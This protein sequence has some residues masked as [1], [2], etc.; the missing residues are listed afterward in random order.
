MDTTL[1]DGFYFDPLTSRSFLIKKG[2]VPPWVKSKPSEWAK[3]KTG[4]EEKEMNFNSH[5][6]LP[7]YKDMDI[8]IDRLGC[9]MLDLEAD[10]PEFPNKG[11]LYYTKDEKKFWI[12]G[13]V[14][15]KNPHVTLLYGL[16]KP[17]KEWKEYIDLVLKD[18]KLDTVRIKDIGFFESNI[19]DE[20]YYCIVAHIDV[21]PKLLEGHYR[22]ELLPHINT[23]PAY[24]AHFTLAYVKKDNAIREATIAFYNSKLR[25]KE[26]KIAKVNYGGK[27]E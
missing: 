4:K 9:V 21:T 2:L 13:F 6:F 7:L 17:A 22:L 12:K 27:E 25:G 15:G 14:A 16:L 1:A 11:D 3:I 10:I 5:D 24:K 19:K 23:F 20:P 26:F 8:N 18:W